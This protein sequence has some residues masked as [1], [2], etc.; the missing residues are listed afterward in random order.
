[1]KHITRNNDQ[2]LADVAVQHAGDISA[3]I[4]VCLANNISLTDNVLS[5]INVNN[6][7]NKQVVEQLNKKENIPATNVEGLVGGIGYWSVGLDFI[8]N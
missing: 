5:I 1:M 8:V 2:T 7:V 3:L 4:D 6:V